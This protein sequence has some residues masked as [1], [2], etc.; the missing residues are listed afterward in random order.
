MLN[1]L[2]LLSARTQPI[3]LKQIRDELLNQYSAD[4]DAARAQFERDKSD[5]RKLGIP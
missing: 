4:P 1:L 2:A 5:L 3:T